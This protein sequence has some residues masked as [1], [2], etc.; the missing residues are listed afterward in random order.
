MGVD[1]STNASSSPQEVSDYLYAIRDC[2]IVRAM[3]RGFDRDSAEDSFQEVT[4]AA[5]REISRGTVF[6]DLTGLRRWAF[7]THRNYCTDVNRRKRSKPSVSLGEHDPAMPFDFIEE[8]TR[9]E[10]A[11]ALTQAVEKLPDI[12][13]TAIKGVLQGLSYQ[14]I[15]VK[16]SPGKKFDS[17]TNVRIHRAKAMLRKQLEGVVA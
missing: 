4:Y 14:E 12:Y 8:L 11:K 9:G 1:Y 2:F 16:S 6:R 3:R 5:L 7:T 15:A 10:D 13:R 17:T